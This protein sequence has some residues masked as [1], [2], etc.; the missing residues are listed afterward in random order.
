MLSNLKF[1]E[2]H[3]EGHQDMHLCILKYDLSPASLKISGGCL[4]VTFRYFGICVAID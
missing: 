1:T 3:I 4:I 2:R